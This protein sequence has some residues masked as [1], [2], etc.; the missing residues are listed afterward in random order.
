MGT[1]DIREPSAHDLSRLAESLVGFEGTLSNL[2]ANV[3]A[4]A[5]AVGPDEEIVCVAGS[6]LDVLGHGF[7]VLA[8]KCIDPGF[9]ELGRITAVPILVARVEFSIHQ[10]AQDGSHGDVAR[11]PARKGEGKLIILDVDVA[12]GRALLMSVILVSEPGQSYIF[13]LTVWT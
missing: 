10:V 8:D 11:S 6:S 1:L 4:F 2:G 5:I 9:E 3:L 12:F 13:V 7:F